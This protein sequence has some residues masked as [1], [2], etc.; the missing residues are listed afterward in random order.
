MKRKL[1]NNFGYKLLSV[2]L[3]I[4]LWI[5][6]VNISDSA[7]TVQ[8]EDIPVEQLNG[9]IFDDLDKLYEVSSG[10]TVDI[11]VKGRRSI[12]SELD[13]DDFIATADLSTMSVTGA[14]QI[15]VKPKSS[16]VEKD[17]SITV[18]DNTMTLI[19]ES[20]ASTQFPIKIKTMGAT[21]DGY[22][23]AGT[24]ASPNIVTVEGPESS[25][26]KVTDVEVLVDVANKDDT[27]V[28]TATVYLYDAYG[29]K[30]ENNK[31][32]VSVE[33]VD[34]TVNIYPT[35]EVPVTVGTVGKPADGYTVSEVIY[36]PQTV[37][38]IGLQ[39]DL[40]RVEAI[41]AESISVAGLSEDLQTTINLTEDLPDGIT[42]PQ[43]SSEVVITITIEKLDEKVFKPLISDIE[44]TNKNDKFK[45]LVSLSDDFAIEI[46]GLSSS[47]EDLSLSDLGLSV[48]CTDLTL[49]DNKDIAIICEDIEGIEYT[50]T[51]TISVS[52]S[53]K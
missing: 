16:A 38:I 52:V 6:V 41:V 15:F 23:V 43:S 20:K 2:V 22:A 4:V 8:I 26:A 21:R 32:T 45:Y 48:D 33:T 11:I 31:L 46:S 10:D 42:I 27:F 40:D 39:E 18:V 19:L 50:V 9:E 37:E 13:V 35:K 1:F 7:V 47:L 29:E 12:V 25:V 3:A 17:I 14:V 53:G 30:I 24:Y 36:Q 5:V 34:V 28:E 49:G 51:G 44:L